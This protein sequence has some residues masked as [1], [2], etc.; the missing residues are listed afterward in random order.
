MTPAVPSFLNP[1]IDTLL[2]KSATPPRAKLF[3]CFGDATDSFFDVP[4]TTIAL[5][6]LE[7]ITAPRPVRPLARLAM[8]MMA[9]R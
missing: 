2:S 4:R 6:C 3:S 8:F 5:R 9:A 1:I 7:P